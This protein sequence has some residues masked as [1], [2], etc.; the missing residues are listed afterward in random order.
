RAGR[1]RAAAR[2]PR[3]P[4][5]AARPGRSRRTRRPRPRS[6]TG[7]CGRAGPW[8]SAYPLRR[9][10]VGRLANVFPA[11]GLGMATPIDEP[12][13]TGRLARLRAALAESPPLLWSFLYFF[14]LLSGYYVLRPVREAMVASSD[15]TAVFPPALVEFFARRGVAL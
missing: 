9:G 15:V 7:A 2:A 14:C 5:R 8:R 1:P 4:A 13:G 6:R 3:D 11:A 10:M 12:A